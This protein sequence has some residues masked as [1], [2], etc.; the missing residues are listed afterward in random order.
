MYFVILNVD[1]KSN[2]IVFV[3][4]AAATT[5]ADVDDD[6]ISWTQKKNDWIQDVNHTQLNS[7]MRKKKN[8][9]ERDI[10]HSQSVYNAGNC[11]IV[12][13]WFSKLDASWINFQ[14]L[15]KTQFIYLWITRKNSESKINDFHFKLTHAHT[16]N[17]SPIGNSAYVNMFVAFRFPFFSFRFIFNYKIKCH[18]H[19]M[20]TS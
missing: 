15:K 5:T 14:H 4:D 7:L 3:A 8:I 6:D 10:K 17:M 19:F 20:P 1:V 11:T 9:S 12:F 16:T 18:K 13:V 2:D